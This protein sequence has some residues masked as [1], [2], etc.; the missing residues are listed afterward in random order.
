VTPCSAAVGEVTPK[1]EAARSSE[2]WYPAATL[3]GVRTKNYLCVIEDTH[4]CKCNRLFGQFFF[5]RSAEVIVAIYG[6]SELA[7]Y[8]KDFFYT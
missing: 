6:D 4:L 8:F 7:S 5:Q 1:M 3:R 2:S